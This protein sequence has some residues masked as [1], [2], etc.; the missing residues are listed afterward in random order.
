M[1]LEPIG[2]SAPKFTTDSR[3]HTF[4][5]EKGTPTALLCAAQGAPIPAT[6]LNSCYKLFFTATPSP[7][8]FRQI[9]VKM[10]IMQLFFQIR[11][12]DWNL[13]QVS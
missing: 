4:Y 11:T 1:C 7:L 6:R 3:S 8:A 5:R 13:A 10:Q 2:K 9:R 12:H